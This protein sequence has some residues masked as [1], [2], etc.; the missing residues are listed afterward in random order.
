ML[1]ITR[2]LRSLQE[3]AL[4][5][6]LS[7]QQL[8]AFPSTLSYD[9][10][11]ADK[12]PI[13][14][15]LYNLRLHRIDPSDIGLL[16]AADPSNQAHMGCLHLAVISFRSLTC[17]RASSTA[18]SYH[19]PAPRL[20]LTILVSGLFFTSMRRC[21]SRIEPQKCAKKEEARRRKNVHDAFYLVAMPQLDRQLHLDVARS[22]RANDVIEPAAELIQFGEQ[23]LVFILPVY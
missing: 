9:E 11:G 22:S 7:G 10:K 15:L 5:C 13:F 16:S 4:A 1:T 23:L 19:T 3:P 17:S 18:I 8:S 14:P 20:S 6:P 12:V 21:Q 2:F